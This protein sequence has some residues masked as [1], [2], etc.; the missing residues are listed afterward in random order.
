MQ[1][2]KISSLTFQKK[3]LK[4]VQEASERV[5]PDKPQ[6]RI[7]FKAA[8]YAIV[9]ASRLSKRPHFAKYSKLPAFF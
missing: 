5:I 9:A 6:K 4:R 8:V 1:E 2:K 3:Y 7:T